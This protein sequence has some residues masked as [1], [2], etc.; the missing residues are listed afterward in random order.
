MTE[1]DI[2]FD[3]ALLKALKVRIDDFPLHPDPAVVSRTAG[4]ECF[5]RK[6][7]KML[8]RI[9]AVDLQMKSCRYEG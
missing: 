9:T 6:G 8:F 7:P 2:K 3:R 4:L 1:V 5:Q